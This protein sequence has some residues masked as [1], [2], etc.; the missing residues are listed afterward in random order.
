[1]GAFLAF[2][3]FEFEADCLS[4]GFDFLEDAT[5]V[6]EDNEGGARLFFAGLDGVLVVRSLIADLGV[7]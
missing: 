4:F 2:F 5:G 6:R 1:M 3:F 7:F